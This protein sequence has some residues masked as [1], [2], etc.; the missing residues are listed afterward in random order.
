[1][2]W[3]RGE[4]AGDQEVSKVAVQTVILFV[5]SFSALIKATWSDDTGRQ[6]TKQAPF[7]VG[8]Q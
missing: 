1:M 5:R 4:A 7:P 6:R 2:G 3:R 8:R